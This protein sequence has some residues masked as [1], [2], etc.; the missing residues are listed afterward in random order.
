MSLPF[1]GMG[2]LKPVFRLSGILPSSM[3][4]KVLNLAQ[5]GLKKCQESLKLHNPEPVAT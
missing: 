5:Q 1:L 3:I 4:L 2:I